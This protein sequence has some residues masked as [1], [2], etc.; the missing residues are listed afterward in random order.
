[1]DVKSIKQYLEQMVREYK[2]LSGEFDNYTP[3]GERYFGYAKMCEKMLHDLSDATL[4]QPLLFRTINCCGECS[5]YNNFHHCCRDSSGNVIK[6]LIF[7]DTEACCC[8][9]QRGERRE[10]E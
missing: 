3:M 2:S 9:E 8:F 5:L 10:G 1:M 4:E 7:R 6:E